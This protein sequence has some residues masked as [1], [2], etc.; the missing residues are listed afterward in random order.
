M[1]ELLTQDGRKIIYVPNEYMLEL[2]RV[3]YEYQGLL[4]LLA[5][6]GSDTPFKPDKERY[7]F[8]LDKYMLSYYEYNLTYNVLVSRYI[9]TS[10]IG[11]ETEASFELS[12]FL[13]R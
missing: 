9:P 13:V 8:L 1:E 4:T 12:A 11:K 3:W 5:Q 2:E 7:E 6:Y 10:D